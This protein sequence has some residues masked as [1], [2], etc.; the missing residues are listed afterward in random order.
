MSSGSW[1]ETMI[2]RPPSACDL[3]TVEAFI[4]QK[5]KEAAGGS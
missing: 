3:D 5:E 1:V 4:V 2:V